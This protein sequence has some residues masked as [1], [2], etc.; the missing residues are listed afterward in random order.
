MQFLERG[1]RVDAKFVDEHLTGA[2]VHR[3]RVTAPAGLVVRR[4]QQPGQAFPQ[5]VRRGELSQLSGDVGVPAQAQVTFDTP[6]Q[7]LEALLGPACGGIGKQSGGPEFG[8]R[9]PAPQGQCGAEH[10][11]RHG[12]VLGPVSR[13]PAVQQVLKYLRVDRTGCRVEEVTVRYGPQQAAG[14]VSE[15]AAEPEHLVTQRRSR[16]RRRAAVPQHADEPV[17]GHR[18]SGF[19]QQRRQQQALLAR[20][21]RDLRAFSDDL[22]RTQQPEPYRI[23]VLPRTRFHPRLAFSPSFPDVASPMSR[24]ALPGIV[25]HPPHISM[26]SG[27]RGPEGGR[28]T[29]AATA[30][31][32]DDRA[33]A[34]RRRRMS[35]FGRPAVSGSG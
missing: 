7:R 16:G 32:G 1:A 21:R 13:P 31:P 8:H 19:H 17:R 22:Q 20:A 24:T 15:G 23:A 3:E 9:L 35:T 11:G 25:V 30:D 10:G 34:D 12:P 33:A 14:A 18:S 28:V 26:S 5:R 2:P 4:H 6:F 29:P 27:S